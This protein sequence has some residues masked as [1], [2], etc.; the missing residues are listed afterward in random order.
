MDGTSPLTEKFVAPAATTTTTAAAAT[1]EHPP[2]VHRLLRLVREGT[3][4]HAS[5]ASALLGR[6]ASSCRRRGGGGGGFDDD[7]HDSADDDDDDG[8]STRRPDAV[9]SADNVAIADPGTIIWDLIGRLVGG[10]DGGG[11]NNDGEHDDDTTRRGGRGGKDG[12]VDDGGTKKKS[13][14]A[15]G[16]KGGEG[17]KKK[18][19]GN[20]KKKGKKNDRPTSGLFDP[21][22][23]T[24]ANCALALERVARCLP[25]EDRRH[26]FEGDGDDDDNSGDENTMMGDEECE[27]KV[28]LWLDV[29]VLRRAAAA[30]AHGGGDLAMRNR[31]DV[32]VECGRPLLSSSGEQYDWDIDDEAREYIREREALHDLDATSQQEGSFLTRRVALQRRILARRLG[33]GG[34][35]NA[36]ILVDRHHSPIPEENVSS[37]GTTRRRR[38]IIDDI[39]DDDDLAPAKNRKVESSTIAPKRGGKNFSKK[40]RATDKSELALDESKK[41][42]GGGISIRALLVLESKKSATTNKGGLDYHSQIAGRHRNPQTLLGSELAYR[43]FDPDWTI[44]HGALLGTLALLRA[45]KVHAPSHHKSTSTKKFGRWPGDILARCV[46]ILALDQFADFSGVSCGADDADDIPSGAI[47]APIREMAAQIVAI[48]LE[49]AP[50]ETS[51]CTHDLL[52]QLYTRQCRNLVGRKGNDEW[53]IR[54]GVLIAWKYVCAIALFHSNTRT[55]SLTSMAVDAQGLRPLSPRTNLTLEEYKA[56]TWCYSTLNNIILQSTLGLTDVSDDNRAVAAQVIRL[57]LLLD[58][59]LHTINIAKES[60]KPLWQAIIAV[61]QCVSSCAADL[62][63]LL[64]ELLARDFAPFIL[65]LQEVLGSLSLG[66][67]LNKLVEFI[68][69]D[70]IHVKLSCFCALRMVAEPIARAILNDAD[71]VRSDCGNR[72]F[73]SIN[74]CA[75]ALSR[76]LTRLFKTHYM[77]SYICKSNDESCN[78][79]ESIRDLSN[80]RNQAWL[81]ILDAIAMLTRSNS[82]DV[83]SIVDDTFI[84]LILRFF[85]ISRSLA[86]S[87]DGVTNPSSYIFTRLSCPTGVGESAPENAFISLMTSSRALSQFFWKIYSEHRPCFLSDAI[88]LTLQSPWFNQCEAG[89]ILHVSIASSAESARPF[90]DKYLPAILNALEVHP[91]CTLREEHIA[92]SAALEDTNMQLI[93]DIEL[94]TSL[95]SE[96]HRSSEDVVQLWEKTF[97]STKGISLDDL[98]KS[99]TTSMTEVSM[100]SSAL[101][102]GALIACGPQ[103]LPLKVTCL[104]R[105]LMT[106]LKNEICHSRRNE[107][108]RHISKLVSILSEDPTYRKSRDKLIEGVCILACSADVNRIGAEYVIELLVAGMRTTDVLEDFTPVWRRLL[109]LMNNTRPNLSAQELLDSTYML[110]VISHA[111]S[112]TCPSFKSVLEFFM[113]SAVE[114]ACSSDSEPLQV[115]ASASIRNFCKIDF[116]AAMDLI[117]PP[118]IARLMDLQNNLDRKGSCKLLL[119][120]L[121]DFEVLASPYVTVFLPIVMRLMTDAV[122]E[123][124]QLAASAF[125]ILVRIA[126][127]AASHM[128]KAACDSSNQNVSQVVPNRVIRHLILGEPLPPCALPETIIS[129]LGKSGT[130]LRPYQMEGIAW[131]RFLADVH[132][133]GAL[134]DDMGLGKTLQALIAVAISHHEKKGGNNDSNSS[135]RRSLVICPSSVVGHWLSEI[136]RFFPGNVIFAPFDF[137]GSAKSRQLDW[138]HR[139]HQSTIIVTSYSVLRNEIDVLEDVSWEWIILDEGHLLKNPKTCKWLIKYQRAPRCHNYILHSADPSV[140]SDFSHREGF[141]KTEGSSQVNIDWRVSFYFF[142]VSVVYSVCSL[143]VSL[144]D[145]IAHV[146]GTPIQNN[147]HEIWATFDFL[148]PNFLGTE[149]SFLREFAKPIIKSQSSGASAAEMYQGMETLKILHQQVLPFVLRRE[150][151]QVIRELPPKIITNVPCSLSKQ[152]YTMYQQTLK[153]SGM[154]EALEMVD[155]AMVGDATG[156]SKIGNHVLASLLQLRLICTHPLLHTLC[157]P[158]TDHDASTRSFTRLDCSGKLSAL[159]DLLRHAGIAEP[160]ITA[161]DN[162]DSGYLI[163]L[164]EDTSDNGSDIGL[165]E[166]DYV[167]TFDDNPSEQAIKMSKCLV[168]AQFTQSLDI[169]EQMLFEPHMSSLRYLRLDGRVPEK[170]RSAVVDRFNQ[171]PD[172]KVLLLT[173]K[174]GGLGLNLTGESSYYFSCYKQ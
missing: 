96:V 142:C 15:V 170:Q 40:R 104:I 103:H 144:P 56:S 110:R 122:D 162:D 74:D 37:S 112:K 172:I 166:N 38:R 83:Q 68:D 46:C 59:S 13:C 120:L 132:L 50:S 78:E 62:L 91:V 79:D 51:A 159:N 147:V 101:I 82:M 84:G 49:A 119:S 85:G 145:C 152:Q 141:K 44:R 171:D 97:F 42:D 77:P 124:S 115:Q 29:N 148:L 130:S 140:H 47:V 163:D 36:P 57:S 71:D 158:N 81:A 153:R 60:A 154:K 118:L 95:N 133:N 22:W 136:K 135:N 20:K 61:R 18:L 146:I 31:L 157:S 6:Y 66:S 165:L 128:D 80:T 19:G 35:L 168:F 17:K 8:G 26:F 39:V 131:L 129:H 72:H 28:S 126:P 7:E 102:S 160:E 45:W 16:G 67:I 161:A 55:L 92:F 107:T 52:V 108:C 174:V 73:Q 2:H 9:S 64:A 12:D 93:W 88:Y 48:L 155:D 143:P 149:L 109:P 43:T 113:R 127:L 150:K 76:L 125:A 24:R 34:I 116:V 3:P 89:Y 111:M 65:C 117:V 156:T 14:R 33:L 164:S 151:S 139:F 4:S 69:D 30:D 27:G 21:N 87:K 70:S 138:R 54:H 23:S 167:D 90:F 32:V 100:R 137:T 105:A 169:V 106:S 94:A 123:C 63:H 41:T 86:H 1:V 114:L 121:H 173:T 11:C 134:C 25:L 10:E 75:I 98:R 58:T 53:E 5:R 99:S